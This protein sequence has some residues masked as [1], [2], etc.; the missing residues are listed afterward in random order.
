[1]AAVTNC[2]KLGNSKQQEF[3]LTVLEVRNQG[4][5]LAALTQ[6]ALGEGLFLDSSCFWWLLHSSLYASVVIL[7][8]LPSVSNLPLP[9][10][11]T[12]ISI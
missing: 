11:Y 7:T 4:V 3:T 5:T 1:M 12:F 10:S 2:H 8:S 9:L 6:E